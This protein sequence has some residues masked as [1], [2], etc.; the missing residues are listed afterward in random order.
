MVEPS[1]PPRLEGFGLRLELPTFLD[2]AVVVHSYPVTLMLL[3][4]PP[5]S[6]EFVREAPNLTNGGQK[7]APLANLLVHLCSSIRRRAETVPVKLG[8]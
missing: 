3:G 2:R 8:I 7:A 5:V 6:G 4:N 1:W